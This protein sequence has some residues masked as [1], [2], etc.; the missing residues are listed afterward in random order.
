MDMHPSV[1]FGRNRTD[2]AADLGRSGR[3]V[4]ETQGDVLA[5][6]DDMDYRV[7]VI[8]DD[9][10]N[11]SLM[12]GVIGRIKGC[13]P[14]CF[15]RPDQA[16]AWLAR[17]QPDLVLL[18]QMMPGMDGMEVLRRIRDDARLRD[19]PV[20][21]IT[22]SCLNETRMAALERGATDFLNKP[23][24][25]AEFRARVRN[26]L[27]LRK[28]Q[29]LL[30]DRAAL[31]AHEVQAATREIRA[32]ELELLMRLCRASEFRDPETG[33][34]LERM[35]RY[36]QLIAEALDLGHERAEEIYRAAPMHDVGKLGVPDAILLKAGVLGV[37]EKVVMRQHTLIGYDILKDSSS[38][39]IQ[40]G[41]EIAVSHHER[42]DGG[43]YPHGLKGEEIPLSG[44]II[45]VADVFDALTSA[46]CYK[47][48]WTLENARAYLENN[49]G[50]HFDPRCVDAFF[51]CWDRVMEVYRLTPDR[52][53]SGFPSLADCAM[54]TQPH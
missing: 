26:L 12:A 42:W 29:R 39:L 9:P 36:A 44:R 8:D 1:E 2:A 22:G 48:P 34:H 10:T 18:D 13:A 5:V 50:G 41:A 4:S 27:A 17:E 45:A 23:V 28:S 49:K 53:S 21:M 30:R 6:A 20:V 35:A 52:H 54:E 31:L 33:A 11:T 3:A 37:E 24:R 47:I 32:R 7:V 16:L 15:T 19:V 25:P 40:L 46:R 38:P 43:G 14:V 51:A